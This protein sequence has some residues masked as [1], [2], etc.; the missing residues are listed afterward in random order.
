LTECGL[1]VIR[2]QGRQRYCH[3]D[4]RRLQE[5]SEWTEKFR[6]FWNSKLD[7]LEQFLAKDQQ[8]D[9]HNSPS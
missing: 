9:Q 2:Q 8:H 6:S 7:A 1:V 5:V 4:L 3:P